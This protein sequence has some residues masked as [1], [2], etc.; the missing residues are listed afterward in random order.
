M[1]AP[2]PEGR[3][4]GNNGPV[5]RESIENIFPGGSGKGSRERIG[6]LTPGTVIL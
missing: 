2:L 3:G 4:Q 5:R 1:M 6:L